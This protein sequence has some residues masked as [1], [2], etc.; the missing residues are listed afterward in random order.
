MISSTDTKELDLAEDFDLPNNVLENMLDLIDT[1]EI[2]KEDV[3]EHLINN[4]FLPVEITELGR[5]PIRVGLSGHSTSK[6]KEM[7]KS[8]RKKAQLRKPPRQREEITPE[9]LRELTT[10]KQLPFDE[11]RNKFQDVDLNDPDFDAKPM[12]TFLSN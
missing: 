12:E 7:K 9:R 1:G 3:I 5:L 2:T 11:A 10:T 8:S 4:G 6:Q